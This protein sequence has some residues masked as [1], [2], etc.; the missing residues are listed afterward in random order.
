VVERWSI[1]VYNAAV[2]DSSASPP[3]TPLQRAIYDVDQ[4]GLTLRD[5]MRLVTQQLGFF[6]GQQRYLQERERIAALV[7]QDGAPVDG[8]SPADSPAG[9]GHQT[10]SP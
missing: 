9:A 1:S 3:F 8:V 2:P 4:L 7:A 6:V 10:G 5:S